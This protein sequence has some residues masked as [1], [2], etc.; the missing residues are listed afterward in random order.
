[1]KTIAIALTLAGL[2]YAFPGSATSVCFD[3]PAAVRF[4]GSNVVVVATV[5]AK[6]VKQEGGAWRQA[7]RWRV[8]E[9]WKGIHYKG[10]TFSSRILTPKREDV[11]VGQ[12][13]LLTLSG[14]EPYEWITCDPDLGLL[15]KSLD[16]VRVIQEIFDEQRRPITR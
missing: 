1:M 6:S 4:D 3:P 2:L 14:R 5:M 7:I 12:A 15:Q 11:V 16:D 13:F 8:D 10:S 9:S